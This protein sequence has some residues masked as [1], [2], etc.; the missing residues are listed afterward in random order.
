[1]S[2]TFY[3]AMNE[4]LQTSR[5]DWL[6]G[7]R[8]DVRASMMEWVNDVLTD[9]L[10]NLNFNFNFEP[11]EAE[12]DLS[13]LSISFIAVG[14]IIA[15]V[16]GIVIYRTLRNT[17]K[18]EHHDLSDIFEELTKK[19]YTVTE[20]IKLSDNADTRRLSIRY[21]YIAALLFL[22]EKNIIEIKPSATNAVI[23][24]QIKETSPTL[25]PQFECMAEA[26][27]L[28]WFGYKDINDSAYENFTNAVNSILL[29]GDTNA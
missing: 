27:H 15:I 11:S 12:Y 1:M 26:F 28:T 21:R 10:S 7:R 17:S 16:A 4:V 20:L 23:L 9:F 29:S 13:I 25:I 19:N 3:E 18:A 14:I 5:Y 24:R 22:N 8:A 6:T 2:M